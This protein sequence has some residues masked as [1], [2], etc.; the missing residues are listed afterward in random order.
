M[1]MET[2]AKN[3]QNVQELFHGWKVYDYVSYQKYRFSVRETR[4]MMDSKVLD[5]SIAE[6]MQT[7]DLM[8]F[9]SQYYFVVSQIGRAHV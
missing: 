4:W 2:S 9:S 6:S 1:Y 3:G 7:L 5:E 8:C